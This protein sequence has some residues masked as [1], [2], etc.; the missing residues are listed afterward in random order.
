MKFKIEKVK[1]PKPYFR[2]RCEVCGKYQRLDNLIHEYTP[3]SAYSTEE[4]Y[5]ICKT[6]AED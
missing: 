6:C 2:P 4:S 5:W 1:D 3:D